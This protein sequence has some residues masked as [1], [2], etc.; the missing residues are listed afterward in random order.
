M[1]ATPS[2]TS[3]DLLSASDFGRL[4]PRLQPLIG[5]MRDRRRHR[6]GDHAV[7]VFENRETVLW[8]VHEVLRVEGRT[9]EQQ[10]EEEL[11]RYEPLLARP[12]ELRSTVMIDSESAEQ[13]QRL[14][15][16]LMSDAN[17]LELRVGSL[18]CFAD[19]VD[20]KPQPGCPV[21][22]L[23]FALREMGV[24]PRQLLELPATL[25]LHG[26]H[27]SIV[28][29]SKDVRS[30]LANDLQVGQMPWAPSPFAG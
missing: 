14:S 3:R 13:G 4:R 28:S 15:S 26:P 16:M 12:G 18:S 8:Q 23:R 11:R 30:A 9:A 27:P 10:A 7:I 29:L 19:C 17:A 24:G 6:L 1:A 5:E 20:R 22:Y 2:L 21:R 25:L